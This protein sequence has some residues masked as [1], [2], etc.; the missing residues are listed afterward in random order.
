M[1]LS[2]IEVNIACFAVALKRIGSRCEQPETIVE[3]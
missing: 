3:Y 1:A 2:L